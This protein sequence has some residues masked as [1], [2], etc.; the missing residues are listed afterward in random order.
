MSRF[1]WKHR[2]HPL[3][4][5][6]LLTV[7]LGAC[8]ARDPVLSGPRPAPAGPSASTSAGFST[9]GSASVEISAP[10]YATRDTWSAFSNPRNTGS[11]IP[12]NR[13][14]IIRVTGAVSLSGNSAWYTAKECDEYGWP[15]CSFPET[16][17]HGPLVPLTNG[18]TVSVFA[19]R[20]ASGGAP[21]LNDYGWY[22]L[23]PAENAPATWE[24]LVTTYDLPVE[25]WYKPRAIVSWSQSS[26][27][28]CTDFVKQYV[29]SGGY[30]V[31]VELVNVGSSQ[32]TAENGTTTYT[33][34]AP[35]TVRS[36]SW[37]Y[38]PDTA[39]IPWGARSQSAY[40]RVDAC[41]G[42]TTCTFTPDS[43]GRMYAFPH[44][45]SAVKGYGASYGATQ[46]VMFD[47]TPGAPRILLRCEGLVG[48]TLSVNRVTRGQTL[49]CTAYKDPANA[50]GDMQITA[51]WFNS[52]PRTDGDLTA[53]TWSGPMA[54]SG[55]VRVRGRIGTGPERDRAVNITVVARPWSQ[56]RLTEAPEVLRQVD[57]VSM[58]PYPAPGTTTTPSTFGRFRLNQPDFR[59]L[60]VIRITEGPNNGD[61]ILGAALQLPRSTV[62]IHPALTPTPSTVSPGTSAY[63]PWHAW[64]DDQNGK[65]SGT[66]RPN[67]IA[68]FKSNVERHEGV[69]MAS[70]SHWGKANTAFANGNLQGKM[71]SLSA[72]IQPDEA[73]VDFDERLRFEANLAYDEFLAKTYYPVQDQF[74]IA[75]T[76][77]VYNIGCNLDFNLSDN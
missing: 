75:D 50:P 64:Y 77:N 49:N 23:A 46:Q 65:P 71:E 48:T 11:V 69:T 45:E 12:P 42:Q 25:V 72:T 22:H 36:V 37:Y 24:T 62:F 41:A 9:I 38:A 7:A 61:A 47:A 63:Q 2:S 67:Q 26:C 27:A 55:E 10:Y 52:R 53:A 58:Q 76:P 59:V 4:A 33:V 31:T 28:G 56:V 51:W 18:G 30:Q 68:T 73:P 66:C 29:E 17:S 3:R 16:G 21:T 57:P 13:L 74:D 43:A 44:L 6:V 8:D 34:S 5:F 1:R 39:A 20:P 14:A 15:E 70:N 19:G 60:P 40:T 54:R 32:Q 35:L